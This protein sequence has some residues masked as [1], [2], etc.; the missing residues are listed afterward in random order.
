[1]VGVK[2]PFTKD[3]SI[4]SASP[5]VIIASDA[6]LK[7]WGAFCRGYRTEGSWTLLENKYHINVLELKLAKSSI[8]N[9]TRI[10]FS[11]VTTC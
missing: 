5:E 3:I 2:S 10:H 4:I 7:G 11:F 9:F 1:M 6:S 8:L